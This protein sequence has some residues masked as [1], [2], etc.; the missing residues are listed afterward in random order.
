MRHIGNIK[1]GPINLNHQIAPIGIL[2]GDKNEWG[3]GY[4]SEAIQIVTQFG[5]DK[6]NLMKIYAGCYES[7]IGSKRA[8]EKSGYEVEGFFR[9][10]VK[11]KNRREGC[12]QLCIVS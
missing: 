11:V 5:F 6:L 8:F 12:W 9:S 2:I 1:I 3:N 7:N 4:A 10:H